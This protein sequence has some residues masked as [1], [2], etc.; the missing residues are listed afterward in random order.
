[1]DENNAIGGR[2]VLFGRVVLSASLSRDGLWWIDDAG[3]C[4]YHQLVALMVVNGRGPWT[5][6]QLVVGPVMLSATL[7]AVGVE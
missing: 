1:M 3:F 2:I 7:A 4:R 6:L 5:G